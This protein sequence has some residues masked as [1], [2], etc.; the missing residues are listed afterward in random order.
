MGN[1]EFKFELRFDLGRD[2]TDEEFDALYNAGFNNSL[3]GQ[4]KG[5]CHIIDVIW[6]AA[7][8]A[9]AITKAK[10]ALMRTIP[11]ATIRNN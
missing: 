1:Q 7:T 3:I 6:K 2:L 4:Q 8:R 5:V 11:S 9:E 10:S